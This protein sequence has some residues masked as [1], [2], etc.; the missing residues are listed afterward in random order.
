MATQLTVRG[1]DPL[2]HESLKK[3]AGQQGLSVNKFIVHALKQAVG[4]NNGHPHIS[5]VYDDLD[6]FI[7]STPLE[8][9]LA[10]NVMMAEHDQIDWEMWA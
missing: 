3:A 4:L 10:F 1:I 8:D 2:L 9:A 6:W 7:N 5:T